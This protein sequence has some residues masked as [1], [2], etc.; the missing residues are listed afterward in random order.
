L[1]QVV[2]APFAELRVTRD[3]KDVELEQRHTPLALSLDAGEI[4]IELSHPRAG[5]RRFFV[6]PSD[7]KDGRRYALSGDLESGV[8]SLRELTR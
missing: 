1:L 3:G 8:L 4:E 2:V 6:R 5:T 7:V